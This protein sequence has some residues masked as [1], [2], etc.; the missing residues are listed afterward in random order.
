MVFHF[1]N[2]VGFLAHANAAASIQQAHLGNFIPKVSE[3]EI[4]RLLNT[5]TVF[6]DARL[7]MDFEAG[8]L[9]GAINVPVNASDDERQKAM[10][11][12][13]KNACIVVYCQTSGC[14]FAEKVAIE[15]ISDGF[16]NVSLFKGDWQKLTAKS[17]K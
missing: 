1:V 15:L 13:P 8:H 12:V 2:D 17:D 14:G 11:N 5:N 7:S 10:V 6:I 4:R 9:E 16:S 3:K